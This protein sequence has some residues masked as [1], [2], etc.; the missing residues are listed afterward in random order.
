MLI[1]SHCHLTYDPLAGQT[2]SVLANM[3]AAG[4]SH[5]ISVGTSVSDA[6]A[7]LAL[8]TQHP[9][10]FATAGIHPHEA[11]KAAPGWVEAL[12]R[13]AG[14]ARVVAI[15][16]TRLDYHYDFAPRD[17]QRTAFEG[18]LELAAQC[19]K[20][21][22]IHCREAHGDV[23]AVLRNFGGV[24]RVVFHCFSGTAAEARE[25]LDAGYWISLTGVVTFRN[26]ESLRTVARDLPGDRLMV[27]TDS[28]YLSPEPVRNRKPNEPATVAHTA[29]RLAEVRGVA[30][31][32]FVAE[33]RANTIRFFGLPID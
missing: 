27:E 10:L 20:P 25:I 23:M 1:D 7:A 22:I 19:G 5:A 21:V 9:Q 33:A 6:G 11:G 29:R 8:A 31:E 3:A 14:A 32:Q 24:G 12:R 26:A 13:A 17:A 28:P 18:Q 15:G 2:E 30:Y 4:V 16:E